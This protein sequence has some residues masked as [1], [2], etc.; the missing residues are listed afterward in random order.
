MFVAKCVC[1][2]GIVGGCLTLASWVIVWSSRGNSGRVCA[3]SRVCGSESVL[4]GRVGGW[5]LRGLFN[6]AGGGNA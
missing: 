6:V 1:S 2:S 5:L 3:A 4:Q